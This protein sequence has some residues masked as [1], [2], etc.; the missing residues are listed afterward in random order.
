MRVMTNQLQEGCILLDDVYSLTNKPII[1]KKTVLTD[2]HIEV[3]RLFLVKEVQVESFLITGEAFRP[4]GTIDEG[5]TPTVE[6]KTI[7]EQYLV[8]VKE[9]KQLFQSWQAGAPVDISKVRLIVIPL[10]ESLLEQPSELFN[11]YRYSTR[12]DYIYHHSVVVALLSG[13][14]GKKLDYSQADCNHLA[15]AGLLSDCGMSKIDPKILSKSSSLTLAEYNEVK[16]HS[17]YSYR[18]IEKITL[19]KDSVKLAVLQH[20]ERIDGTGYMLGVSGDKIHPFAKI[21]SV[22]DVYSA[23]TS[24]RPY[25]SR[26]APFKVLEQIRQEFFGKFDVKVL[27]ALTSIIGYLSIGTKVKLSNGQ[28]GEVIYIDSNNPTRP[29]IKCSEVEFIELIK[30]RELYIE[31]IIK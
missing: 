18:M 13:Y 14:L 6:E 25:N 23:M 26:Q 30:Q 19:I 4:V 8:A 7:V 5:E 3:L 15:V 27:E 17:L 2:V 16:K 9:Y 24:E 21:I 1:S 28:V 11:F 12:E 29:M 20:H 10:L 22:A 31:E